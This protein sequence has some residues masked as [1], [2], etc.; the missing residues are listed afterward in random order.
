MESSISK[1]LNMKIKNLP[2][3]VGT[4]KITNVVKEYGFKWE[5]TNQIFEKLEEEINELK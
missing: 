3:M 1:N 4:D 2:P 5:S